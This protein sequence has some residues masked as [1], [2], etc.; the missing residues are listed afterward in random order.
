[1][2]SKNDNPAKTEK[3]KGVEPLP[4]RLL[5]EGLLSLKQGRFSQIKSTFFS[6]DK[7]V[8]LS[9]N[10][11]IEELRVSNRQDLINDVISTIKNFFASFLQS[12]T[13]PITVKNFSGL[14]KNQDGRELF[15][16]L[17]LERKVNLKNSED[18]TVSDKVSSDNE[19]W[20]TVSTYFQ[21]S[22]F[23]DFKEI[24]VSSSI[25]YDLSLE[26][27]QLGGVSSLIEEESSDLQSIFEIESLY[28]FYEIL[29]SKDFIIK[30]IELGASLYS[31]YK[32]LAGVVPKKRGQIELYLDDKQV[33]VHS[34]QSVKSRDNIEYP[35]LDYLSTLFKS[36]DREEN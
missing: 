34:V 17:V 14:N 35:N 3:D 10:Y 23:S 27:S 20:Q 13:F 21:L 1:M 33:C 11:L 15:F 18:L 2:D 22:L 29:N 5:N 9:Y 6:R 4:S 25:Y 30:S 31:P 36:L 7:E 28:D 26:V 8:S 32:T 12:S 24:D 16:N 19:I